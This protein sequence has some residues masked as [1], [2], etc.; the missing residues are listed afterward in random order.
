[1]NSYDDFLY[2]S[3]F[4]P[5][6]TA[7]YV[8]DMKG[9]FGIPSNPRNEEIK[10]DKSEDRFKKE[11]DKADKISFMILKEKNDYSGFAFELWTEFFE[12]MKYNKTKIMESLRVTYDKKFRDR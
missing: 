1:M 11:I 5:I 9:N 4:A 8:P 3:Y 6:N 2:K 7:N 12:W 10:L